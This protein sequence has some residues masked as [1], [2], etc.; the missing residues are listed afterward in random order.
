MD[1]Y[2]RD[3]RRLLWNDYGHV[4]RSVGVEVPDVLLPVSMGVEEEEGGGDGEEAMRRGWLERIEGKEG[5][6]EMLNAY[7][8]A[9]IKGHVMGFVRFVAI[10]QVA[11]CLWPESMQ[12]DRQETQEDPNTKDSQASSLNA[13]LLKAL[14]SS[15]VD[16]D[17]L[18][19][20][21]GYSQPASNNSTRGEN[22]LGKESRLPPPRS[23][24]LV[25]PPACYRAASSALQM[26]RLD[27]AA[28]VCGGELV[29][30]IMANSIM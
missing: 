15:S 22:E 16:E 23:S 5:D 14:L 26:R 10:H 7:V 28:S 27:W 18:Q 13:N 17:T 21:L 3:Y 25:I 6:G 24:S 29:R 11:G 30:P 9:L 20:L 1:G 8:K 2:A 12:Q 4:L 19:D